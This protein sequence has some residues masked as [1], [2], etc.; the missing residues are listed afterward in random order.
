LSD[1]DHYIFSPHSSLPLLPWLLFPIYPT[2]QHP[3]I[4]YQSLHFFTTLLPTTLALVINSYL[5]HTPASIY[6]ISIVTFFHHTPPYPSCLCYFLFIPH[7]SIHLSD[8]NRYIFSPYSPLPLL[9]WLLISIYP[10]IQHPFIRYRSLH[11]FTTLPPTPLALAIN[12]Y[13]SHT[14]ASICQIPIATF[15]HHTPLALVI[16]SY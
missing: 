9:P 15:F 13:L 5:S 1:I 2:L 11:F 14:P 7:S 6:Q 3:F 16:N 10:I 8:I 12:F 4:R